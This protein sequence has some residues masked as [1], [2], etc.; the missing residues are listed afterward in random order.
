MR[1]N[2]QTKHRILLTSLLSVFGSIL[3]CS[4]V[5]IA[6]LS[7]DLLWFIGGTSVPNPEQILLRLNGKETVLEPGSV[8]YEE[9][10]TAVRGALAKFNNLS[11]LSVGLSEVTLDEYKQ[12]GTVI[13]LHFREPVNFHLPFYDGK[14]TSLLIPI[15][16]RHAG[17]GYV[18]RGRDG[19]WW[20]GQM[21]MQNPQPIY[22]VLEDL[23]YITK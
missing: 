21:I 12:V 17:K 9:I 6:A 1:T 7:Q 11:P 8:G 23:G 15:E 13:E 22:T 14:P 3:F 4:Y 18:F 16:G 10:T 20:A 2:G 19:N 5:A